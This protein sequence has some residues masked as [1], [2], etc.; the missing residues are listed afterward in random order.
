MPA[1]L[2]VIDLSDY[3]GR[4]TEITAKFLEAATGMGFM[5][6]IGHGISQVRS[7]DLFC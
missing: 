2:A 1:Q 4:R 5:Y 6:V 3:N 7:I